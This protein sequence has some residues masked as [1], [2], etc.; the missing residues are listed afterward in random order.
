MTTT[1][2]S[3]E[4]SWEENANLT[5]LILNESDNGTLF[6]RPR[7]MQ[8]HARDKFPNT[9]P[10]LITFHKK[11]K[12]VACITGAIQNNNGA[13]KFISPFA[14]S[15]GGLVYHR[16]LS[17]KEIE[18]I[19]TELLDYLYK[20]F[21]E[22]QVSSS[23]L[24][25]SR[26]GKS[27]YVDHILLTQGFGITRSDIILVHEL[28]HEEKLPSRIDKKTFTELKQPL[29]KN[30]LQLEVIE[31]VDESSY[32]LL[33]SCQERLQ[34]KPTH[35]LNELQRIEELIPGTIRTFKAF[36][37]DTLVAGIIT[38][39]LN[40]RILSTF[41]VFDTMAGRS[42]KANHFTYYH[43]IKYATQAS[44]TFL[45]FG[46]SSFGWRPN[47]PLISFKEKFDSKPFLRNFFEKKNLPN[48]PGIRHKDPGSIS[49]I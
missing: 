36:S 39:R 46:C 24:F 17:F 32:A 25:Q 19:Y 3:I 2:M 38:F 22:I 4:N 12:L 37:G 5:N 44:H 11:G 23:P 14:S 27:R 16:E 9:E 8:Y 35:T 49:Y 28:D 10:I 21:P 40:D 15:Y 7:F 45:D 6:H 26:T 13:K 29:Y 47:Y 34:S 30:K 43:V 33:L 18:E 42:L 31:G 41:Y 20:Q 1:E 48:Q